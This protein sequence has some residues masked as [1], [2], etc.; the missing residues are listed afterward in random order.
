MLKL[1][2]FILLFVLIQGHIWAQVNVFHNS[3]GSS[4]S[5]TQTSS[6]KSFQLTTLDFGPNINRVNP[7][8]SWN[9]YS[10][11]GISNLM[12]GPTVAQCSSGSSGSSK[13]S[14]PLISAADAE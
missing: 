6:Q 5:G 13:V 9:A 4:Q 7:L 14:D 8:Q 11:F 12:Q 10:P 2:Y 3:V 1:K